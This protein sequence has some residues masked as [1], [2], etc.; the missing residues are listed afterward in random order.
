MRDVRASP[1][2]I[3]EDVARRVM[4]RAHAKVQKKKKDAEEA[5]HKRKNLKREQL[6]KRRRQQRQDGLPVEASPTPSLSADS[7]DEDDE[8]ERGRGPLDHL[9]DVGETAPGSS[10]SSPTFLGGGGEGA[11]GSA[12]AH[13]EDEADAP[14][15]RALGKRAVSLL[16]STVDVG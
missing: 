10:A 12:I 15:A 9:P 14:E 3:P 2:P 6:E 5:K 1:P 8:S 7:S 4:N 11:S 13:P 16:G